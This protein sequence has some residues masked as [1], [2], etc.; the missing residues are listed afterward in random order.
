MKVVVIYLFLVSNETLTLFNLD[1]ISDFNI[2]LVFAF[3]QIVLLLLYLF[4]A[5]IVNILDLI[6]KK[7]YI[8]ISVSVFI[9]F[10]FL[11]LIKADYWFETLYIKKYLPHHNAFLQYILRYEQVSIAGVFSTTIYWLILGVILATISY[12]SIQ[13]R[14]IIN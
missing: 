14:K 13:K 8:I 12:Y 4:F 11:V 7:H 5:Q 1:R 2:Y 6:I 3:A 9:N 10:F